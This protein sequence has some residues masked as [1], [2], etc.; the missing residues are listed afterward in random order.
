MPPYRESTNPGENKQNPLLRDPS[1]EMPG[2]GTDGKPGLLVESVR[3]QVVK[4]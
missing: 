3:K 2:T 4:K 1:T